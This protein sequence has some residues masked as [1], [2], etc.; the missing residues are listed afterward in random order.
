MFKKKKYK[1]QCLGEIEEHI[2]NLKFSTS[3]ELDMLNN[4][5]IGA[6]KNIRPYNT[7][8]AIEALVK[9]GDD[10]IVNKK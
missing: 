10:I 6:D 2:N 1:S 4:V 9:Y 5:K 8:S 7:R 3:S